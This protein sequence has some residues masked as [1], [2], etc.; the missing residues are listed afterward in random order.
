MT[1]D[2]SG[3]RSPEDWEQVVH[4]WVMEAERKMTVS[5]LAS[6]LAGHIGVSR[7]EARRRIQNLIETGLLTYIY[8]YGH[9]YVDLGFRR[10]TAISPRIVLYPPACSPSPDGHIVPIVIEPGVAFGDGR[11]PTTRLAVEGLET[12]WNSDADTGPRFHRGID[13]GTG[14]G[15]LAIVAARLGV[16]Q[17]D[18][19][20]IDPCALKEARQNIEHNRLERQINLRQEVLESLETRYDLVMANLRLPTLCALAAWIQTHTHPHAHLLFSGFRAHEQ[21]ALRKAYPASRY[22]TRWSRTQADWGAVVMQR[23]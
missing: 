19:V 21:P 16:S 22:R 9:S 11:H 8:Q 23:R 13:I 4:R 15:I 14:S 10:P 20:D 7:R 3:S 5:A 17:V 6:R 1:A 2:K 18:A 12:V